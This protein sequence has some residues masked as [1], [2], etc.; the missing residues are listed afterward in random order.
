MGAA[1]TAYH[2]SAGSVRPHLRKLDYYTISVASMQLLRALFPQPCRRRRALHAAG[3]ALMPFQ[4]TAVSVLNLG[5]AE[6]HPCYYASREQQ[7]CCNY[8]STPPFLAVMAFIAACWKPIT[9]LCFACIGACIDR[10]A[11]H[12]QRLFAPQMEFA[13]TALR[14]RA[15]R[16]VY[17]RHAAV[18]GLG[19]ACFALEDVAI[20]R[21]FHFVHSM[22][23]LQACYA[24]ASA[25]ALMQQRE[26]E[27]CMPRDSRSNVRHLA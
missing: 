13:R 25:N 26:Q 4:P 15:L 7:L 20:S 6:V 3:T 2:A 19:L 9:P 12:K 22:W 10:P 23:H 17:G 21:G 18:G 27:G 1:A 11:C 16:R 8:P 14:D 24:V 5:L